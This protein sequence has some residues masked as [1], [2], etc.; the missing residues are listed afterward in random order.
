M[1]WDITVPADT[2]PIR[3]GASVI[4]TFKSDLQTA[5]QTE[6]V[7]PGAAP[8]TPVYRWKPR[9]G[10]TGTR[11]ANDPVN[12][13]TTYFNT[14]TNTIQVDTGTT[15]VDVAGTV[16]TGSVQAFMGTAVPGGWLLCD[17]SAVSRTTYA[18]LFAAI[19]NACGS[20]DGLTTFNV[21][22]L[23]GQ[24]LRGVDG[25]AGRDPDTGARTAMSAGGNTGNQVGSVQP[26]ATKPNGMLANV[27]DPG[28]NHD[29]RSASVAAGAPNVSAPNNDGNSG[30]LTST[31][32]TGITVGLTGDNE[33]R[34][35]NAYVKFIIKT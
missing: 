14:D 32:T 35:T 9:R 17:G 1:T 16:P 34:P 28:H 2:D 26:N 3:Q 30:F 20:G 21:P 29:V 18:G 15:W 4:R 27:T 22:D 10:N 6:G 7:F 31:N 11:P 13:G 25:G 24:F 23:R 33:T 8:A 19:G 12:P 5:L